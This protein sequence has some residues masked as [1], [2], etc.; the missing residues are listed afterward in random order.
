[1]PSMEAVCQKCRTRFAGEYNRTFLGFRKLTCPNCSAIVTYPLSS[2]LRLFYL[3]AAVVGNA[4]LVY[5]VYWKNYKTTG[6]AVV[7]CLI[8]LALVID[9]LIRHRMK[10]AV[11]VPQSDAHLE[12]PD[13]NI[14]VVVD[15][16][17]MSKKVRIAFVL[18][19]LWLCGVG[20]WLCAEY[21]NILPGNCVFDGSKSPVSPVDAYFFSCEWFT[22]FSSI[23]SSWWGVAFLRQG[24]QIIE[25]NTFRLVFTAVLPVVAIWFIAVTCP[26]LFRW[27]GRGR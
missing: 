21:L 13:G 16:I 9:L 15:R 23:G 2:K 18:S 27:V 7:G 4:F 26:A 22:A 19:G 20:F 25:L 24:Q 6:P 3:V 17:E 5:L 10:K 11:A 1:M 14:V 12:L 8:V